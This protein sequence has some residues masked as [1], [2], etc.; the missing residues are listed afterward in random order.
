MFKLK[1][2]ISVRQSSNKQKVMAQ[3][4]VNPNAGKN[5]ATK[6]SKVEAFFGP[7]M[8]GSRNNVSASAFSTS[9]RANDLMLDGIVSDQDAILRKYYKDIYYYD[10]VAGSAVD[11]MST[12]P[13][14]D[15]TLTGATDE[16]LE[17]YKSSVD[18][19]NLRSLFPE[20]S[21]D[22]LTM[23]AFIG[24]LVFRASEKIFMDIIPHS[25]DNCEVTR[26]PFYGM[27]PTIKV[28]NSLE[29]K[30]FMSSNE[31]QVRAMKSLL[32]DS[33]MK[34]LKSDSYTLDPL[35]TIYLPR[36]A[37]TGELNQSFYR[38][39]LPIYLLE[40]ILYRGT[41]VESAKRQRSTLHLQCLAGNTLISTDSGLRKIA[42][43]VPHIANGKP[44][45][46]P[47]E[48]QV[49]GYDGLPHNTTYWHYRGNKETVKITTD[50]GIELEC[51]E[52]HRILV[53][54]PKGELK[55]KEASNIDSNEHV[56]LPMTDSIGHDD[57]LRL[58]KYNFN[59]NYGHSGYYLPPK[60]MIPELAY[61]LGAL[62]G[63]G[64]VHTNSMVF[65]SNDLE[66]AT[67]FKQRFDSVF[68]TDC[69]LKEPNN[70]TYY[71]VECNSVAV[72]SYLSK[73]GLYVIRKPNQIGKLTHHQKRKVPKSILRANKDA[74]LA[75]IAGYLDTDGT[76]LGKDNNL[77]IHFTSVSNKLLRNVQQLLIDLGYTCNLG[78][79]GNKFYIRI[80]R[81]ETSTL[82][83]KLRKWITDTRRIKKCGKT[84]SRTQGIPVNPILVA[85][86]KCKTLE[87][88]KGS[89]QVN[90]KIYLMN[91]DGYSITPKHPYGVTTDK[92]KRRNLLNYVDDTGLLTKLVELAKCN[93]KL[94]TDLNVIIQGKYKFEK[95][96]SIQPM[97]KQPVYD[98]SM[99][100]GAKNSFTANGIIVHNCG[101]DNWEPTAEELNAIVSLFQQGDLDPLGAILATRQ[102]VQPSEIRQGGDFWKYTDILG[103]TTSIKLRSLGISEA[104]LSGDASFNT[105]EAALSVFIESIRS[106]RDM[107]T[108]RVFTNKLFPI[109][110]V[111]NNFRRTDQ[112]QNAADRTAIQY[113]VNDSSKLI[114][115][116]VKWHKSLAPHTDRD[117]LDILTTLTDKGVP[118]PL[119]M[120]AAAGGISENDLLQDLKEDKDFK[121]KIAQYVDSTGV[122]TESLEE[123]R[124][125]SITG[126]GINRIGIMNR[127][128]DVDSEIQSTTK[129]G[130]P[131]YIYNQ[132]EAHARANQNIVKA[133]SSL[134][135]PN[136]YNNVKSQIHSRLNIFGV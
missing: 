9:S 67:K 136:R 39:I 135:D 25:L 21:V 112:K 66:C 2:R 84:V 118:I 115:P 22:Y 120:W 38:R 31:P 92:I 17:K 43:L 72:C 58:S 42:D 49:K 19:L 23:G 132:G 53:L 88:P 11:L 106:Y 95:V 24:T 133:L 33:L 55:W 97:G 1:N 44:S 128:Y 51:T 77:E 52:D 102:S 105:G 30:N 110:A 26:M 68:G 48:L 12:L 111:V 14:S 41:L 34:A 65:R 35:T 6:A 116:S 71:T 91:D 40:K 119:R 74:K 69:S 29:V 32:S 62:S 73:L 121:A 78:L 59:D 60:Q 87:A 104:F 57:N 18:R 3:V 107:L 109:I 79:D 134:T 85:L 90:G 7:T 101:D 80:N 8:A 37:M 70:Y 56:C 64:S 117:T 27:D 89:R 20:M 61:I 28:K 114:I 113:N 36:R 130:K 5:L 100:K 93:S 82:Y 47:L 98:L 125:H 86:D 10:S 99:E 129:T 94:S 13:F 45:S 127:D 131:K 15:W 126:N 16:Q 50:S 54:T 4:R 63:D 81:A 124:L 83:P 122:E 75:Y 108:H 76:V 103:D 96:I 46:V 123:S